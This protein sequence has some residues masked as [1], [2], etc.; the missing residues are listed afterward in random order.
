MTAVLRKNAVWVAAVL[1][2]GQA[3][4]YYG[5]SRVEVIPK[6]IPWE[7]FPAL[8]DNWKLAGEELIEDE[9]LQ[10]LRPDEY[11]NRVYANTSSASQLSL[12]IAYFKTQRTG[13][14]PHSPKNCLPG[15]GWESVSSSVVT[16]D[17][18]AQAT[19]LNVNEYVVRKDGAELVVYYWFQQGRRSFT[20]EFT[21]QFYAV[22]ELLWH[23]RTD[24]TLVRVIASKPAGEGR[25]SP[26]VEF[27]Q[28]IYP[29]VLAHVN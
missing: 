24:T 16:L 3:A 9:F 10:R 19:R 1:L 27:V 25:R 13:F 5:F 22:P 2:A 26:A 15:A 4:F 6:I 28:A 14:A 11:L 18:P 23:G 29:L 17:I 12:F 21:A 20:S 8:V 7:Q